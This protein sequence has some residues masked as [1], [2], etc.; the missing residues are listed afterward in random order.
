MLRAGDPW[1]IRGLKRIYRPSLSVSLD[2]PWLVLGASAALLIAAGL[3]V[4]QMGRSFLPE[5]NEGSLTV[6]AVTIPG[7]SLAES[8]SVRA[9]VLFLYGKNSAD[10]P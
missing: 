9:Y 6:S 2:H 10:R 4:S 7:T 8:D 1:L 3:G 5:F